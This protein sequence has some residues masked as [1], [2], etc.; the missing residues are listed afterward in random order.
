MEDSAD[1]ALSPPLPTSTSS[2]RSR[3]IRLGIAFV[4]G[5]QLGILSFFN[6]IAFPQW[7]QRLPVGVLIVAMMLS[8][9]FDPRVQQGTLTSGRLVAGIVKVLLAIGVPLLVL[10][11]L[12][13]FVPAIASFGVFL[14]PL[15]GALVV[16]FTVGSENVWMACLSGLLGWL[17][18]G[19]PA[20]L[21]VYI[22]LREPGNGFGDLAFII[23]LVG[24]AIGMAIAV[25]GGFLGRLLRRWSFG[26][27]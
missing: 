22:Q 17:G 14:I 5:L 11:V 25:L 27:A 23:T 6:V 7:V 21:A 20:L 2:T 16:A 4:L 26:E 8:I 24:V 13:F 1:D 15:A 3:A 18:V 9:L 10:T 19:L 12:F